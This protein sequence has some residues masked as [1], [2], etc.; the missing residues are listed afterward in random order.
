MDRSIGI[1][2]VEDSASL[3]DVLVV[4]GGATGL[5]VAVDAASRG[6]RVL[7]VERGDFAEATSS[8]STKLVHGGVR[9]LKQGNVSLVYEALHERGLLK[10]NAP[11]LVHDMPFVIPI[12]TW[13]ESPFYGL[14]MKC[15][16]AMAGRLGLGPSEWLGP[17]QTMK[18]LP[19]VRSKGLRSGVRYHD[20]QFD[21]ARLAIG[22]AATAVDHGAA[23]ANYVELVDFVKEGDKIVG[24]RLRDIE[25]GHECTVRAKV[26]VNATGVFCDA[27][28]TLDEPKAAKHVAPSQGAHIVLPKR[29]LP[30]NEALMVPRTADGR[31]LFAVPWHEHVVVGT[32]DTPVEGVAREPRPLAEELEF[33]M[34]HAAKYLNEAPQ[35]SDVLSIYAGLRPL[36]KANAGKNTS[37]LSRDHSIW[38]SDSGLVTITGGKWTTYRRMAEDTLNRAEEHFGWPQRECKTRSLPIHGAPVFMKG[39]SQWDRGDYAIYGKDALRI[40]SIAQLDPSMSELLIPGLSYTQAEIVW[41]VRHEMARGVADAL[42]RRTRA[43]LLDARGAMLAAPRVAALMAKELGKDAQWQAEQV[44]SFEALAKHYLMG[45]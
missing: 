11:H 8:R 31:V 27:L 43:L 36:V 14:G 26:V 3:W 44:K 4:G 22:L 29:F 13:W 18:A 41:A 17:A 20:G 15:Y 12:Y 21:D 30:G 19:N 2:A 5:G 32:T 38:I 40:Q 23:V 45:P 16:D 34:G 35:P 42:A 9:Y 37:K 1:A 10:Q 7:L 24:G 25:S 6:Y 28:R 33:L 39:N